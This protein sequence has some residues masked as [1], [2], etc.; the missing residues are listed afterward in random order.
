MQ[1]DSQPALNSNEPTDHADRSA[2][3]N[4]D[5]GSTDRIHDFELFCTLRQIADQIHAIALKHGCQVMDLRDREANPYLYVTA[6]GLF[7]D[8][9]FGQLALWTPWGAW[10]FL[11]FDDEAPAEVR[12]EVAE[13][14]GATRYSAEDFGS[15]GLASGP[16]FAITRFGDKTLPEAVELDESK[17]RPAEE[18]AAAWQ[19]LTD[20]FRS[21]APS[22]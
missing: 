19:T 13:L 17:Y 16:V 20:R 9:T 1:N 22:L 7:I 2:A 11:L 12:T 8:H 15:M 5:T 14:L 18:V 3:P 4:R 6:D 10:V 21:T